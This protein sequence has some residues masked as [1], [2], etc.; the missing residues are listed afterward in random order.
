M[1][2]R[3]WIFVGCIAVSFNGFCVFP[4]GGT[5]LQRLGGFKNAGCMIPGVFRK[6]VEREKSLAEK[7]KVLSS[8]EREKAWLTPFRK[9]AGG[10]MIPN[11]IVEDDGYVFHS[12]SEDECAQDGSEAPDKMLSD[13]LFAPCPHEVLFGDEKILAKE[14]KRC[15]DIFESTEFWKRVLGIDW[16]N[17]VLEELHRKDGIPYVRLDISVR[18]FLR[19]T[20]PE[21]P[22]PLPKASDKL[23][24]YLNFTLGH[25]EMV[26]KKTGKRVR[27]PGCY[28][29]LDILP[30]CD[31][32]SD[33]KFRLRLI[34][35]MATEEIEEIR[36]L[37]AFILNGKQ[38]TAF[39]EKGL[40]VFKLQ[41]DYAREF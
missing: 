38:V 26:D 17:A 28:T 1:K 27:V 14:T 12:E 9:V 40:C 36:L 10:K 3:L 20:F 15:N 30:A 31:L 13:F 24:W 5:L 21:M 37:D 22:N 11:V 33:L 18:S 7:A 25:S 29:W 41:S 6:L 19:D 16:F 39:G 34:V 23:V 8:E 2:M 35:D 32:V 4:H